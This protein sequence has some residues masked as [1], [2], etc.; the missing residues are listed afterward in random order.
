MISKE[1]YIAIEGSA[2]NWE[3]AIALCGDALHAYGKTDER[4]KVACIEREKE[5]PTGLPATI[6]V[7][8]PHSMCDG[9][10]ESSICFLRLKQPVEFK[11]MDNDEEII[12]TKL[13]FNLAIKESGEHIQFLQKLMGF[14][15]DEEA[16]KKCL[17]LDIEQVRDYLKDKLII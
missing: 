4:F 7:A 2:E 11:R 16:V 17:E 15:M 13:I 6:P 14:L 8:I 1:N 9:I 10:Y 5:Y 12:Q 3:D